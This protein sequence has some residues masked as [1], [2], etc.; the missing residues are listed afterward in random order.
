MAHVADLSNV[1][2][3]FLFMCATSLPNTFFFRL[4]DKG[5]KNLVTFF[6]NQKGPPSE[7]FKLNMQMTL[8][9][10]IAIA[11][12]PH[13]QYPFEGNPARVSPVEIQM[14]CRQLRHNV[15]CF[16]KLKASFLGVLIYRMKERSLGDMAKEIDRMR[17]DVRAKHVDIRNNSRI[18]NSL[19]EFC[20]TVDVGPSASSAG[21]GGSRGTKRARG[22]K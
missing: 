8:T 3:K 5:Y 19:W 20:Q 18:V 10:F 1:K 11:S 15:S 14:I 12:S 13:L 6:N 4:I 7:A 2:R 22:S 17:H 21:A 16:W 9:N